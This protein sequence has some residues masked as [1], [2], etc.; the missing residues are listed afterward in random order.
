MSGNY[1]KP[2][3]E[4]NIETYLQTSSFLAPAASKGLFNGVPRIEIYRCESF[5]STNDFIPYSSLVMA[6]N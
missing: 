5:K 2:Q 3:S 1:L 4:N 6:Y